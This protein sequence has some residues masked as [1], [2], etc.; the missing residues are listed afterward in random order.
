[1]PAWLP[2]PRAQVEQSHAGP[3]RQ[4]AAYDGD[5]VR[6]PVLKRHEYSIRATG[7]RD[8]E[9]ISKATIPRPEHEVGSPAWI[10]EHPAQREG[11]QPGHIFDIVTWALEA[12]V[13]ATHA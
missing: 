13:R 1:M 4:W 8:L 6:F 5:P 2:A 11:R 12:A 3:S 9:A 10:L 7:R